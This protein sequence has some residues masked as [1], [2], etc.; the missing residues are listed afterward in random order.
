MMGHGMRESSG[1]YCCGWDREPDRDPLTA[2]SAEAGL[3][4]TSYNAHDCHKEFDHVLDEYMTGEV[5]SGA[6]LGS[7]RDAAGRAVLRGSC[8]GDRMTSAL[9]LIGIVLA[10]FILPMAGLIFRIKARERAGHEPETF[11]LPGGV[12]DPRLVGPRPGKP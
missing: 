10:V 6:T 3:F 4:Q 8:R 12:Q 7:K 9:I 11:S 1:K 5:R 2:M